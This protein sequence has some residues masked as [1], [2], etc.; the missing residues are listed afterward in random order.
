MPAVLKSQSTYSNCSDDCQLLQRFLTQHNVS[1]FELEHTHTVSYVN[2]IP[3]YGGMEASGGV[4]MGGWCMLW[5]M[6]REMYFSV[7]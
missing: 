7:V 5:C 6:F 4:L 2:D 1:F 3:M